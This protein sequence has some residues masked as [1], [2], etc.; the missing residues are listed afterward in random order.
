M[1]DDFFYKYM[2]YKNKYFNLKYSFETAQMNIK[3][4]EFDLEKSKKRINE[5]YIVV[6]SKLNTLQRSPSNPTIIND[7]KKA[8]NDYN[9]AVGESIRLQNQ[10]N[11]YKKA[12]GFKT[13]NNNLPSNSNSAYENSRSKYIREILIFLENDIPKIKKYLS[14]LQKCY[15]N[16]RFNNDIKEQIEKQYQ[17]YTSDLQEKEIIYNNFKNTI[18]GDKLNN[19]KLI[20]ENLKNIDLQFNAHKNILSSYCSLN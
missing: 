4:A 14:N 8:V 9:K 10:V 18:V 3:Q 20:L 6:T 2:K 1:T 13:S 12:L 7:H 19:L 17:Y 5:L 11:D 15:S 16:S